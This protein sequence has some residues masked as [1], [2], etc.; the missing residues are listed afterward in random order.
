MNNALL[1][2]RQTPFTDFPAEPADGDAYTLKW[3][4]YT[5]IEAQDAWVS[6][7]IKT[8]FQFADESKTWEL[9]DPL[10]PAPLHLCR[11]TLEA[12]LGSR[13][14]VVLLTEIQLDIQKNDLEHRI[15][16]QKSIALQ[17]GTEEEFAEYFSQLDAMLD[18]ED[19][20]NVTFPPAPFQE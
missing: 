4:N 5:Y 15:N 8:H 3:T 9:K 19:V 12:D 2:Y 20:F 11:F 18:A 1:D 7:G 14:V 17:H 16:V 10:D 13:G 6:D